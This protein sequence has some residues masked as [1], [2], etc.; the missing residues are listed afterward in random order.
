VS[1]I[2]FY[3][4]TDHGEECILSLC[5]PRCEDLLVIHQPDPDLPNR[6]LATCGDCKTWYVTNSEG[7]LKIPVPDVTDGGTGRGMV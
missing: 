7:V 1:A 3:Q 2:F 6:L 4:E 5:C